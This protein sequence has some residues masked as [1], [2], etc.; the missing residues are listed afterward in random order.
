MVDRALR[1]LGVEWLIIADV[2]VMPEL[3]GG[4]ITAAVIVIAEKASDLRAGNPPQPA[5][6]PSLTVAAN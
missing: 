3:V 1:A 5:T 6:R 2:S 4:D